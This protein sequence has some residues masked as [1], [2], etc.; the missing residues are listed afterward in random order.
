MMCLVLADPAIDIQAVVDDIKKKQWS[1]NFE[2]M[3]VQNSRQ[4]SKKCQPKIL[5]VC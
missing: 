3:G 1:S 4:S 5:K 2:V